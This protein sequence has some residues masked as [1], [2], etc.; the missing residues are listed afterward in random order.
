MVKKEIE[1]KM[2]NWRVKRTELQQIRLR[3]VL[4]M[5]LEHKRAE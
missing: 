5:G 4:R 2:I 1:K 3:R